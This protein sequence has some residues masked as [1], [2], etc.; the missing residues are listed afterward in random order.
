[1]PT[2]FICDNTSRRLYKKPS[3]IT[4]PCRK[5]GVHS[6]TWVVKFVIDGHEFQEE[7]RDM[8]ID[9][10]WRACDFYTSLKNWTEEE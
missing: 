3:V 4:P 9:A 10:Y 1:M 5:V 2:P 8:R 7:W 6:C